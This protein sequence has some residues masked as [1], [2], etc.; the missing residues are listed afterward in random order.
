M[1]MSKKSYWVVGILLVAVLSVPVLVIGA[2]KGQLPFVQ[3]VKDTS[4][5]KGNSEGPI[6]IEEYGDFQCPSCQMVQTKIDD[7]FE[8]HPGQIYLTFHH[9]PLQA[10]Q[11]S[12]ISH[13]SAECANQQ[14]EFWLYHDKI[15]AN[16]MVWSTAINPAELFLGYA[17]DIGLDTDAFV[18]CLQNPDITEKIK[19]ETRT[20]DALGI[21][22]TPTFFVNQRMLVGYK[23]FTEEIE[24]VLA[25]ELAKKK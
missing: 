3:Q 4:K 6:K 8:K 14:G 18:A 22:S 5:S 1:A 20:G 9:F 15:Y 10:H 7:M 17:K 24:K 12:G 16:Q 11:F 13:Q 21:N 19:A 23:Q 25:E 2:K